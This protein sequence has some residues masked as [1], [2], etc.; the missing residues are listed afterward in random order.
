MKTDIWMPLYLRDYLTDTSRL[1]TIEHGAYLLLLMDYWVNGPLPNNN[2]ILL[3]ITK[4][5]TEN[6][7]V[8][9]GLL[10]GFFVLDK[11]TNTWHNKRID[12]ELQKASSRRENAVNN[13][14]KGGRPT[15]NNPEDNPSNNPEP[16]PQESSS[17]S[18]SPSYT[19]TYS[20]SV[21]YS[22]FQDLWNAHLEPKILKLSEAR[23][24]KIKSRITKDK[25]FKTHFEICL[26]KIKESDFLCGRKG[27]W[28]ATFDWL[29]TNETNY[30]K[31]LEGNYKN[32]EP[33]NK[34]ERNIENARK[35]IEGFDNN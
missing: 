1:S 26:Q 32:N 20:P 11:N 17:P 5:S 14:K 30:I 4:L 6:L 25:D 33:L 2:N 3:Q 8:I 34:A 23:K 22:S 16:N 31:V 9:S 19:H 28:R 21:D 35:A 7:R 13:G 27:E 24:Q 12:Q 15:E 29:I 10:L 18:P